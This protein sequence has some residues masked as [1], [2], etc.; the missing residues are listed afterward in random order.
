[1][2]AQDHEGGGDVADPLTH[3]A[4]VEREEDWRF[5]RQF[6]RRLRKNANMTPERIDRRRVIDTRLMVGDSPSEAIGFARQRALEYG[7]DELPPPPYK[8]IHVSF[9]DNEM[10]V[11]PIPWA[12]P[13]LR[14]TCRPRPRPRQFRPRRVRVSRGPRK[15]RAPGRP[16]S[17]DP[18]PEPLAVLE[19]A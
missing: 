2:E 14:A 1:L 11:T 5:D 9:D 12:A 17:D 16:G 13:R 15:A 6:R 19:P 3:D 4:D 8:E 10:R 7:N 18:H